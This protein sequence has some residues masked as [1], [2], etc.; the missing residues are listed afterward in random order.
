M[1][2]GYGTFQSEI[3]IDDRKVIILTSLVTYIDYFEKYHNEGL[4]LCEQ[5]NR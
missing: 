1:M 5:S 4:S 2:V 3:Y